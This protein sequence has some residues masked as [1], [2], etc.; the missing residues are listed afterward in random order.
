M[1]LTAFLAS[2][3]DFKLLEKSQQLHH[4]TRTPRVGG[5]QTTSYSKRSIETILH[6]L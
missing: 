6:H 5:Q 1:F 3:N 2:C 4:V